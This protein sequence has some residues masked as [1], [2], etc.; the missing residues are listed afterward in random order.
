MVWSISTRRGSLPRDWS[1]RREV[2][3]R[4]AG[5]QCEW[6]T[7]GARC[8]G[9]GMDRGHVD[10]LGGHDQLNLLWLCREHLEVQARAIAPVVKPTRGRA[11]ARQAEVLG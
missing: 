9:V 8:A 7:E 2:T 1:R 11:A 10:P 5:G 4:L 3:R 6:R